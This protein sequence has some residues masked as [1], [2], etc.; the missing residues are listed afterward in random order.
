VGPQLVWMLSEK[1]KFIA[2]TA[3]VEFTDYYLIIKKVAD[4]GAQLTSC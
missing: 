1:E 2:S 3:A 4:C